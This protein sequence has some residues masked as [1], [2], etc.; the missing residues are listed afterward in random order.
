M[1]E[2]IFVLL[3]AI[4]CMGLFIKINKV[5]KTLTRDEDIDD[6]RQGD[7]V[8]C[9]NAAG[10]RCNVSYFTVIKEVEANSFEDLDYSDTEIDPT[11][12]EWR[13]NG[14][15]DRDGHTYPCGWIRV[16]MGVPQYLNKLSPAQYRK[17]KEL[18]I[19]INESDVLWQ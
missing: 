17:C 13:N 8:M 3:N 7:D 6:Y 18:E 11:Y 12:K 2:N 1:D 14:W 9:F 10:G 15:I 4:I 5:S 19:Y 16:M